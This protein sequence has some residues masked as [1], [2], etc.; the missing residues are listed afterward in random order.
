M[1]AELVFHEKNIAADGSI[2]E[3]KIWAVPRSPDKPHGFKYSLVYIRNGN[4]V[5]GYD[6]A[7]GKGDHRHLK[8]CEETYRF[9]G[10]ARLMEDFRCDIARCG[11]EG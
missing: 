7:E 2:I 11:H 1:G 9:A 3:I 8:G 10:I 4:R 6:N 5:V